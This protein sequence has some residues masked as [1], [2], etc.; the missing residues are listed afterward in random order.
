MESREK[1]FVS[2]DDLE[3]INGYICLAGTGE[4]FSGTYYSKHD[5]GTIGEEVEVEEGRRHGVVR[6]FNAE[7]IKIVEAHFFRGNKHGMMT[8]WYDSGRK[9]SE[10]NMQWGLR[11]GI[12]KI[13]YENGT[14]KIVG[15]YKEDRL[16]GTQKN[17]FPTAACVCRWISVRMWSMDPRPSGTRKEMCCSKGDM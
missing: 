9:R 6:M 4:L 12:M 14:L 11:E 7:G 1:L 8:M 3:M 15:Y 13:W 16:H 5:N 17:I 10:V 2:V